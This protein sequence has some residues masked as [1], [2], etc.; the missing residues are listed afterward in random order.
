MQYQLV[1]DDKPYEIDDPKPNGRQLLELAGLHPAVEHLVFLKMERGMLEELRLDETVDLRKLNLPRFLSFKSDRSF[2]LEINGRRFEWG[3]DAINGA[4]VKKLAGVD[5]NGQC[6]WF[7]RKDIP[8]QL[9]QDDELVSLEGKGVERFRTDACFVICIEGERFNW[10]KATINTEEIIELGGWDPSQGVIE[11]NEETQTERPLAPNEIIELKPGFSF[12]KKFCWKR[13]LLHGDRLEAE[14]RLL[15][16]HYSTVEYKHDNGLHWFRVEELV[17]DPSCMPAAIAAV[18]YLT[19]GYPG[20]KPYGFFVP[21]SLTCSGKV[22]KS[23]STNY[24]PP[25]PGEWRFISWDPEH[26][27]PTAD[28]QTGDNLWGWV[29]GF[30][31]GVEPS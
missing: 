21:S 23:S 25:F 1:I 13:G 10:S 22:P 24:A 12:G 29:R 5:P 3:A 15:R 4:T 6:V 28:V 18:F 16:Q 17:L 9:V 11:V 7:E 30:K 31:Q 2:R 19:E 20:A 8:D 14:L 26:W 27:R